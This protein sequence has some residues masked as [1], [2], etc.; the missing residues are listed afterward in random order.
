MTKTKVCKR[1]NLTFSRFVDTNNKEVFACQ[2]C[3]NNE[4]R[5][6]QIKRKIKDKLEDIHGLKLTIEDLKREVKNLKLDLRK[7]KEN[8]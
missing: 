8:A 6:E 7:I 1:H 3:I 5:K 2:L 4:D